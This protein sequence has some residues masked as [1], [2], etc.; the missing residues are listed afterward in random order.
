MILKIVLSHHPEGIVGYPEIDG[1]YGMFGN[2]GGVGTDGNGNPGAGTFLHS[3]KQKSLTLS[4][5]APK[6]SLEPS[7]QNLSSDTAG[8]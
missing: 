1:L 4:I 2:G 8:G 6:L 7:P 3:S 5:T